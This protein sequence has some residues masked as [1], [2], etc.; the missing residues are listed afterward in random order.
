MFN[1]KVDALECQIHGRSVFDFGDG[2]LDQRK[3][4][5]RRLTITLDTTLLLVSPCFLMAPISLPAS[6]RELPQA[7]LK[8]FH[9]RCARVFLTEDPE[10]SKLEDQ[11]GPN[12]YDKI[13]LLVSLIPES[14]STTS[15]ALVGVHSHSPIKWETRTSG[16]FPAHGP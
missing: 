4:W 5:A 1:K 7:R 8:E 15:F 3:V 2:G 16:W 9:P 11:S 6:L 10:K 13:I 14:I 12:T